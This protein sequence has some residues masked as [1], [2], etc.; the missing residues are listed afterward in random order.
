MP[1]FTFERLPDGVVRID[2]GRDPDLSLEMLKEAFTK[3]A[4]CGPGKHPVLIRV[5]GTFASHADGRRFGSSDTVAGV[6]AACAWVGDWYIAKVLFSLF[7]LVDKPPYPA[8]WFDDEDA[9]RAWLAT[10]ADA[11]R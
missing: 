7:L 5:Q 2:F 4:A 6:T 11:G 8:R 9:A 1:D 10:F 3:V